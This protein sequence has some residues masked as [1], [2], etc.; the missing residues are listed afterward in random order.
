MSFLKAT[1]LL[2]LIGAI[3]VVAIKE[4][5]RGVELIVLNRNFVIAQVV[6]FGIL[7]GSLLIMFAVWGLKI[8]MSFRN[9]MVWSTRRLR[10]VQVWFNLLQM[11]WPPHLQD[12][13]LGNS[14][15]QSSPLLA[16]TSKQHQPLPQTLTACRVLFCGELRRAWLFLGSLQ[17]T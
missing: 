8:A 1:V 5:S 15:A 4:S 6:I 16:S 3:I 2:A 14:D 10:A 13:H 12:N 9:K 7:L 11:P 17:A